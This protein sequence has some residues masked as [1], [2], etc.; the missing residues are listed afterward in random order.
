[1]KYANEIN[2]KKFYFKKKK[3]NFQ[4]LYNFFFSYFFTLLSFE[5]KIFKFIINN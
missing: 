5:K 3:E 1:M 2:I 4:Y